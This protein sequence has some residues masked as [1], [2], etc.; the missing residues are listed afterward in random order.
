M[1]FHINDKIEELENLI[2]KGY[3]LWIFRGYVAVNK[4]GVE[5]IIDD[6]YSTLPSD[7]KKA[8]EFLNS[9]ITPSSDS[10]GKIYKVLKDFETLMNKNSFFSN[11]TI[12]DKKQLE[13]FEEN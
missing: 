10:S 7:V 8:R 4:R 9:E 5:K 12:L 13:N 3:K 1:R 6:I 11:I 2:F